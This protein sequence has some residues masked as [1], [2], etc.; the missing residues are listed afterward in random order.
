M[1]TSVISQHIR[2]F[3]TQRYGRVGAAILRVGLCFNQVIRYSWHF[4]NFRALWGVRGQVAF[5][6]FKQFDAH[7]FLALPNLFASDFMLA[8][9]LVFST[10]VAIAYGVGLWP[11][12]LCWPFALTTFAVLNRNPYAQDAGCTLTIILSFLLCLED[13]GAY[14]AFVSGAKQ[15]LG[16][17]PEFLTM[18]HN[19]GRFLICWQICMVY[20]FAAFYKLGGFEWRNGLALY[21]VLRIDHFERF[22]LISNALSSNALFVS[23]ATYGTLLL[24]GAFPFVMWNERLK[25]Y[26]VAAT[27]SLHL[28]IAALLG[29]YSFSFTMIVADIALLSDAWFFSVARVTSRMLGARSGVVEPTVA[30]AAK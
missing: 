7:S 14:L 27:V 28:G 21:Y 1:I 24:Q 17:W 6:D 26:L 10:I 8:T 13:S 12:I 4:G 16:F 3:A 22:P 11:R 9:T 23:V 30:K 25:P 19:S 20:L 5:V 18:L 2:R 15:K 29:L